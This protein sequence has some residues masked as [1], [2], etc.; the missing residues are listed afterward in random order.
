MM[1]TQLTQ[2]TARIRH[3]LMIG[4]SLALSVISLPLLA[5]DNNPAVKAL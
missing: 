5:A 2:L 4:G 1:K 3:S